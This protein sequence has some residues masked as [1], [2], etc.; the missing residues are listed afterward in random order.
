[1]KIMGVVL[2]KSISWRSAGY[3][4]TTW[5]ATTLVLLVADDAWAETWSRFPEVM[6]LVIGLGIYYYARLFVWWL[7]GLAIIAWGFH[8]FIGAKVGLT[9]NEFKYDV[10]ASRNRYGRRDVDLQ[11]LLRLLPVIHYVLT[12]GF[13]VCVM[14]I[15]TGHAM[16]IKYV[17]LSELKVES[18]PKHVP[19]K[20]E[21]L[22]EAQKSSFRIA[23][24]TWKKYS[25]NKH[26]WPTHSVDGSTYIPGMPK[27]ATGGQNTL[28]VVNEKL[29][30]PVYVKLCAAGDPGTCYGLRHF[31]IGPGKTFKMN[32]IVSGSY[33][34]RYIDLGKEVVLRSMPITFEAQVSQPQKI[35]IVETNNGQFSGLP[36]KSF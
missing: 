34:L 25:P 4:I 6:G 11:A 28:T 3:L 32:D 14:I 17:P 7:L 18:K 2:N 12:T 30:T 26:P 19:L 29:K 31:Y 20:A 10:P 36:I 35:A 22:S 16:G 24:R 5:L 15:F 33:E 8:F 13:V 9:S 27:E 1:M 23:S 21:P